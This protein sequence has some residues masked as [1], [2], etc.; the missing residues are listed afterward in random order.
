ME[1]MIFPI[2]S[3]IAECFVTTYLI[4]MVDSKQFV[5][6]PALIGQTV[7]ITA[8]RKAGNLNFSQGKHCSYCAVRLMI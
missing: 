6:K 2:R 5:Q 4:K 1:A 7:S 3:L 8:L